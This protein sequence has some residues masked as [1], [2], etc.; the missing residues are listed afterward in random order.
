MWPLAFISTVLMLLI[1]LCIMCFCVKRAIFCFG[2]QFCDFSKKR[3]MNYN[4][5]KTMEMK[6]IVKPMK[7]LSEDDARRIAFYVRLKA[8]HPDGQL[9]ANQG[10]ATTTQQQARAILH[11]EHETRASNIAQE[12]TYSNVGLQHAP[13]T[14]TM[15]E[16]I[17]SQAK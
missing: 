17:Y 14:T 5:A 12:H 10:P 11:A 15:A 2:K 3:A 13:S 9:N 8:A 4:K 6:T 16:S 7:K 1:F